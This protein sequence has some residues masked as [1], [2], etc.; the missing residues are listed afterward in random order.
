[1]KVYGIISRTFLRGICSA[2]LPVKNIVVNLIEINVLLS[3]K[4]IT[5]ELN[6]KDTN[7]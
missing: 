5:I 7:G 1:M 3:M 4:I 6:L 2:L